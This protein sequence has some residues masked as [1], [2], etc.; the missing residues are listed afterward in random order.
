VQPPTQ[1]LFKVPSAGCS[2]SS[3]AA[4]LAL[5]HLVHSLTSHQHVEGANSEG[6]LAWGAAGLQGDL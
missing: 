5:Q 2:G 6:V 3:A 4:Q 1:L